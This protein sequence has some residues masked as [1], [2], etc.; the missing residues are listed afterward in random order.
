MKLVKYWECQ[1]SEI[2]GTLVSPLFHWRLLV[3][4]FVKHKLVKETCTI[5][6]VH[7]MYIV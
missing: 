2:A 7:V 6:T 4:H 5:F 1:V 3:K